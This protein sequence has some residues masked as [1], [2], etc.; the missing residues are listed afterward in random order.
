MFIWKRLAFLQKLNV[1]WQIRGFI[2]FMTVFIPL[3]FLYKYRFT[4]FE[5]V[6]DHDMYMRRRTFDGVHLDQKEGQMTA[7]QVVQYYR[8]IGFENPM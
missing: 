5:F 7:E 6:K 8:S 2:D 4:V 3:Q 1:P